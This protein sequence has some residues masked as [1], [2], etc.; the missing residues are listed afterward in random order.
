MT[1]GKK[2]MGNTERCRIQFGLEAE[3][4]ARTIA[5][6]I[7]VGPVYMDLVIGRPGGVC[8]LTLHWL[9]AGFMVGV[10][11]PNK[12]AAKRHRIRSAARPRP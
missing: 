8:L 10:L 3:E 4:S 6:V 9:N 12:C 11:I 7:G 1:K 5:K 2:H